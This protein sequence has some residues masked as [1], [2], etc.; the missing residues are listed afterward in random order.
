MVRV[1]EKANNRFV[2]LQNKA[3][4]YGQEI[5]DDTSSVQGV[6]IPD[7]MTKHLKVREPAGA[8]AAGGR[9]GGPGGCWMEE[10][11]GVVKSRFRTRFG[12]VVGCNQKVLARRRCSSQMG[13]HSPVERARMPT[14]TQTHTHAHTHS[15][16]PLR[17]ASRSRPARALLL[18]SRTCSLTVAQVNP[19][20]M[21]RLYRDIII[22]LTKDV[23][24]DYLMKRI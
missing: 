18:G 9:L 16:Y 1:A 13:I 22:P 10:S 5:T 11:G 3:T 19:E 2:H 24:V 20:A 14:H 21:G 23:E 7:E 15:T 4:A 17:L 12:F 6:A 8:G